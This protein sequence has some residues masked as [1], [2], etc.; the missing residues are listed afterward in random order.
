MQPLVF[1]VRHDREILG[2]IVRLVS[3]LVV[4]VL[5]CSQRPTEDGLHHKPV[6]EF[7]IADADLYDDITIG[8]NVTSAVYPLLAGGGSVMACLR[9]ISPAALIE[10]PSRGMESPATMLAC[11]FLARP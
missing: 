9:A 7:V 8:T 2:S 6:L 4:H 11:A 3:V 10:V 5:I 1:G